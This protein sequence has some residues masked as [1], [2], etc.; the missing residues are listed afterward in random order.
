MHLFRFRSARYVGVAN[1]FDAQ[2]VYQIMTKHHIPAP[3]C[4][5]VEVAAQMIGISRA[6]LYNELTAGRLP[7]LKIGKRRLVRVSD[8]NRYLEG[9]LEA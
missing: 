3:L 4:V 9:K 5:P 6:G 8:L 7:S 2:D 1:F